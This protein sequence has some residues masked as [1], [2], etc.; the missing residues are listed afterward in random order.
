[1]F[2]KNARLLPVKI[3]L[4]LGFFFFFDYTSCCCITYNIV[5]HSQIQ[6]INFFRRRCQY[7]H[8]ALQKKHV[9]WKPTVLRN[10]CRILYT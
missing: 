5:G 6:S 7:A 1:M 10:G 9:K 8:L 4:K 2:K 3:P